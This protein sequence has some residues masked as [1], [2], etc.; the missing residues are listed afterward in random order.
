[1]I[2]S[3]RVKGLYIASCIK[4]FIS[5]SISIEYYYLSSLFFKIIYPHWIIRGLV[6]RSKLYNKYVVI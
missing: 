6:V 4:L 1:M 2:G 5:N 3:G